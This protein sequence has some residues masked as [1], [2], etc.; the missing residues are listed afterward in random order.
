MLTNKNIFGALVYLKKY[1]R[2]LYDITF[3]F[4][5]VKYHKTVEYR[6]R[7]VGEY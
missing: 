3:V 6:R 1:P 2:I 4:E 5:K 7:T